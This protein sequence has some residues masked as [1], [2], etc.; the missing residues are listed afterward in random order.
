MPLGFLSLWHKV[1]QVVAKHRHTGCSL[2]LTEMR[3]PLMLLFSLLNKEI[4]KYKF[5]I[6]FT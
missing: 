5:G 2:K 3:W 1:K 6:A 4:D